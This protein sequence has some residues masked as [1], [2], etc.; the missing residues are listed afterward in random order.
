MTTSPSDTGRVREHFRREAFSFDHLY[1][2]ERALQRLLRSGLFNRR[3]LALEEAREA[4][5][6]GQPD[7]RRL[8]FAVALRTGFPARTRLKAAAGG[9]FPRAAG[10]IARRQ[11]ETGWIGASGL[12]VRRDVM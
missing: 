10:R 8:S 5:R 2:E 1:D 7:A 4:L 12:R 11:A 9:F 3:E 6:E